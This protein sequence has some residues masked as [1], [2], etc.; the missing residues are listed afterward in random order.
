M[1]FKGADPESFSIWG[2]FLHRLPIK[3]GHQIRNWIMLLI[4]LLLESFVSF[5][6]EIIII[7]LLFLLNN[8]LLLV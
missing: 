3:L 8:R 5:K 1:S 4:C 2:V 7:F 6:L